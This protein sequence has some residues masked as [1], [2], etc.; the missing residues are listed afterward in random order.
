MVRQFQQT[1]R[2]KTNQLV[3]TDV[4]NTVCCCLQLHNSALKES[5]ASLQAEVESYKETFKQAEDNMLQRQGE[6]SVFNNTF[7]KYLRRKR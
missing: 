3:R 7:W 4:A 2:D 1:L 6:V 5:V